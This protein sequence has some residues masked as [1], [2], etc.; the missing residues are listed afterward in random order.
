MVTHYNSS[1]LC[2]DDKFWHVQVLTNVTNIHTICCV[3]TVWTALTSGHIHLIDQTPCQVDKLSMRTCSVTE[4]VKTSG[5]CQ[6]HSL[7]ATCLKCWHKVLPHQPQAAAG[8][9]DI[10]PLLQSSLLSPKCVIRVVAIQ[11]KSLVL[12]PEAC[13]PSC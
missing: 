9:A 13:L 5:A 8:N 6:R 10:D 12:Y 11:L 1:P 7:T 2:H 3:I 4:L